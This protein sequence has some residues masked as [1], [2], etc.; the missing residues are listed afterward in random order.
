MIELASNAVSALQSETANYPKNI[1]LWMKLMAVSFVA[2]IIFVYAKTGARWVLLAFALNVFGLVV[3]KILFPDAS[4]TTIGTTVHI[5]FWFP[6]LWAVLRSFKQ[7]SFSRTENALYDW[8]YIVWLAWACLL[9]SI[10]L[11]FDFR[12]AISS[13]F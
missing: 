12:T 1:Q 6:I 7:I 3:G 10:S 2:S 11:L 13:L 9:M 5:L 8:A 4:R